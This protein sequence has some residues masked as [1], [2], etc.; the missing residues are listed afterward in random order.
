MCLNTDQAQ[1]Y[2][3]INQNESS[4]I[5]VAVAKCITDGT[6]VCKEDSEIDE[7]IRNLKFE[8]LYADNYLDFNDR[9]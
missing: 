6:T 3:A 1:M 9:S 8:V 2:G 5:W 4:G 7:Y